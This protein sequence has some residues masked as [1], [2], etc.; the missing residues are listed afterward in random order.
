MQSPNKALNELYL[1]I[2]GI[3]D[4]LVNGFMHIDNSKTV[5]DHKT[6]LITQPIN[7]KTKRAFRIQKTMGKEIR[8]K[9]V[10]I[11]SQ[12]TIKSIAVKN[13]EMNDASTENSSITHLI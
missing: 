4:I 2:R 11:S 12:I 5:N 10:G 9:N 6:H 13:K 3:L 7:L 8:T 1:Y